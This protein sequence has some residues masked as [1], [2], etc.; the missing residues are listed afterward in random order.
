MGLFSSLFGSK[1]DN[2]NEILEAL[3]LFSSASLGVGV[4]HKINESKENEMKMLMY[5]FGTVD[6]IGQNFDLDEVKTL[7]L[8]KK[9]LLNI[10]D[11]SPHEVNTVLPQIMENSSEPVYQDCMITGG[12]AYSEWVNGFPYAPMALFNLL[13]DNQK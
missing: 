9:F 4:T 7:D 2:T 10:L 1:K 5:F 8:Y 12:N 11:Y 3:N 13:T 6:N